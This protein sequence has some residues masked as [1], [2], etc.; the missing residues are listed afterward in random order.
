MP[1]DRMTTVPHYPPGGTT[2]Y[3]YGGAFLNYLKRHHGG[4]RTLS[5][6]VDEY[7]ERAIPGGLNTLIRR[8]TGK[9]FVELYAAFTKTLRR[10]S[11]DFARNREPTTP[12]QSLIES[13]RYLWHL[14][15][16]PEQDALVSVHYDGH[17]RPRD[18]VD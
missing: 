17:S 18:R 3:M 1:I 14:D 2:P 5:Q 8:Q 13:T 16:V 4:L 7:G 15:Y 6:F 12:A 9:T 11:A 10:S